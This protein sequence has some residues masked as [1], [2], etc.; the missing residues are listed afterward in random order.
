LSTST[1]EVP[2]TAL[3]ASMVVTGRSKEEVAVR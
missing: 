1:T 3:K 2:G